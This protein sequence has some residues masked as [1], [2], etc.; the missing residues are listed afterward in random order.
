MKLEERFY[1]NYLDTKQC[2]DQEQ[3]GEWFE[4]VWKLLYPVSNKLLLSSQEQMNQYIEACKEK[5][6]EMLLCN[7][8][9]ELEKIDP[10]L[11]ALLE[12][13]WEIKEKLD[14]DLE[15]IYKG[16]PAAKSMDEILRSYPGFKAISAYRIANYFY[17]LDIPVIPRMLTEYAHSV[18]GI[19]IHPGAQID[20]SF[21]IDHGTGV[22]IG[23][24][25]IIGKHVKIYQGVTLGG[26]SVSKDLMN[27]KRHPTIEDHVVIYSGASILGGNT[28][29]GAH[30]IIGGNT[31]ITKSVAPHSKIYHITTDQS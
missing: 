8:G 20:T 25:C 18:T 24:T 21:C 27:T 14:L 13:L 7:I 15:A 2:I 31:F 19:D 1:Q 11:E 23:E 16:D 17:T 3:V 12:N 10:V 6:K 5:L 26:L 28:T 29:I 30:S 9:F 22:V 4:A